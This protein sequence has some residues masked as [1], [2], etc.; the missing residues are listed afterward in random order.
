MNEKEWSPELAALGVIGWVLP[1][2]GLLWGPGQWWAYVLWLAIGT[3]LI[4]LY[5]RFSSRAES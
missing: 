3:V 1:L 5:E 2:A 4:V